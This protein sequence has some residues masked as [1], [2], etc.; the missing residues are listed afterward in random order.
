MNPGITSTVRTH[1]RQHH[2]QLYETTVRV[3]KL[4]RHDSDDS[5]GSN[6]G[7]AEKEPFSVERFQEL[8]VRWVV[9]DDQ[10]CTC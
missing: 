7:A 6:G 3:L 1:L 4:K 9:S 5:I 10:V 8:L 2:A